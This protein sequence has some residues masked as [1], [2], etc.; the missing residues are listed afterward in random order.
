MN[1]CSKLSIISH[2]FFSISYQKVKCLKCEFV[3]LK[4]DPPISSV[5]VPI[6]NSKKNS[7]VNSIL[8]L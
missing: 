2:L 1:N 5:S 4:Y 8:A 3:S 6:Q 7:Y